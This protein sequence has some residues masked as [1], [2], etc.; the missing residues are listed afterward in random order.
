MKKK[1]VSRLKFKGTFILLFA[2]LG[3]GFLLYNI[4]FNSTIKTFEAETWR[5]C[6]GCLLIIGF[7]LMQLLLIYQ[8]SKN[9]TIIVVNDK[10]E[11]YI[12]WVF[13]FLTRIKPKDYYDGYIIV[14]EP[15]KY[16]DYDAIYLLRNGY[17]KDRLSEFNYTNVNV[18]KRSLNVKKVK[19]SGINMFKVVL[20]VMFG[21]KVRLKYSV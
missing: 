14:K 8:L 4:I 15:S 13:P 5:N 12:N 1:V 20:F 16:R 19:C 21:I 2:N 18:L 6:D 17:V 7:A 10:K 9:T 3:T 11:L